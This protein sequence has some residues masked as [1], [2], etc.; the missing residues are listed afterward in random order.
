MKKTYDIAGE[1]MGFFESFKGSKPAIDNDNILIVRGKSRKVLPI[2]E[3]ES[4]LSEVGEIIGGT[5][6]DASSEKISEILKNQDTLD[7]V[8]FKNTT[9]Y[10]ITKRTTF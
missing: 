10:I 2:N 6:L 3:L 9:K 1:I 7:L 8:F 5:E 4:K